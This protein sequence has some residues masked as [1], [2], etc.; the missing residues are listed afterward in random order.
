MVSP[1]VTEPQTVPA[2]T[3]LFQCTICQRAFSRIDHLS[4]HV[5]THTLEKPYACQFCDK[6]FSRVDLLKR[7]ACRHAPYGDPKASGCH[8]GVLSRVGQAC[9]PCAAS[10]IKCTDSKPCRRCVSKNITCEVDCSEDPELS[11][12]KD[13]A[14][15]ESRDVSQQMSDVSALGQLDLPTEVDEPQLAVNSEDAALLATT[16]D[17]ATDSLSFMPSLDSQSITSC[18]F[19]VPLTPTSE[20]NATETSELY[21]DFLKGLIDNGASDNMYPPLMSAEDLGVGFWD[22]Y[23]DA[24][25]S[26]EGM[27]DVK[28]LSPPTNINTFTT[29]TRPGENTLEQKA[30]HAAA[31]AFEQ[32]GWNWSPSSQDRRS[33][34][35]GGLSLPHDWAHQEGIP[36][37]DADFS[38]KQMG[39]TD[40]ERIMGLLLTY[41]SKQHLARMVSTFPSIGSLNGL[42]HRFLRSHTSSHQSW[43]HVPTFDPTTLRPE[44]L[45]AVLAHGACST[46]V[47]VMT[48]L[49]YA[50]I[51]IVR[52]AVIDNWHGDNSLS[53][54]LQLLQA[55]LIVLDLAIW[56]GNKCMMEIA[57]S[58]T[59]PS[60][61]IIRRAGWLR[62]D[63]YPVIEPQETDEGMQLHQKWVAW[64]QQESR[65]RLCYRTFLL[66]AQISMTRMTSPTMSFAE[67]SLS[68]PERNDLWSAT[69]AITW[70][71]FYLEH[72][73]HKRPRPELSL[74]EDMR[75]V[76]SEGSRCADG[77]AI[78]RNTILLH[79]MWRLI[80]GHC[81]VEDLLR[82]TTSD[83]SD[84]SCL[85]PSRGEGLS[86]LLNKTRQEIESTFTL[87]PSLLTGDTAL[88][89]EFLNMVLHAPIQ[90]LQAFAG[91]YGV[92][93]AQRV[94][95]MLEEWTQSKSARRAVWH[96]GQLVRAAQELPTRPM[97]EWRVVI[98][99]HASLVFWAY[100]IISSICHQRDAIPDTALQIKSIVRLDQEHD[101]TTRRFINLGEGEPCLLDSACSEASQHDSTVSANL[102]LRKAS[103]IMQMMARVLTE[104]TTEEKHTMCPPLTESFARLMKELARSARVI[105]LG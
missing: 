16:T 11:P 35:H 20:L 14:D 78:W 9:K 33:A 57:E 5:R 39:L 84:A 13:T 71:A 18:G 36:Q 28:S 91:K 76:M 101:S 62:E 83:G 49:G 93:A 4:R 34:E 29:Q 54:D 81:E 82:I 17:S 43:I 51:D 6:K 41:C 85:L 8:S 56:S 96:A 67:L 15:R 104:S 25:M 32:S 47:E 7:H 21:A 65:K 37:P 55:L 70:K 103:K 2:T 86:K 48:K 23:L 45:A 46:P 94:Y 3:P 1:Q 64:V 95:P 90:S 69:N 97:R 89:Q 74:A 24:N 26:L 42:V 102:P 50:M 100:G 79:G 88:T 30:F 105:G 75:T 44:L 10:K 19:A 68:Y 77:D 58:T 40:R 87:E 61:T 12:D 31:N 38:A 53:R 80:W 66:D 72:T 52:S 27:V 59:G 22:D 98:I 60:I 92:A 99:Y 73:R 63:V